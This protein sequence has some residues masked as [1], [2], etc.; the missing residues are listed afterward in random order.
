[1][2]QWA[3]LLPMDGNAPVGSTSPWNE[4][5]LAVNAHGAIRNVLSICAARLKA[6]LDGKPDTL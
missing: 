6:R 4:I 5:A 1:M 2:H 3:R